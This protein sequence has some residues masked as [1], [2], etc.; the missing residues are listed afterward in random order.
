MRVTQSVGVEQPIALPAVKREPIRLGVA[1]WSWSLYECGRIA[2]LLLISSFVFAP[3]FAT[4]MVGDPVRGQ[5]LIAA[6]TM[7]VGFAYAVV[8][9]IIGATV[10]KSGPRKPGLMLCVACIVPLLCSLWWARPD[11]AG[12]GVVGV[13]VVLGGIAF[14]GGI[15]DLLFNSMMHFS[16]GRRGAGKASGVALAVANVVG[17]TAL[18]AVLWAFELP[19]RMNLP[20]LPQSPL[21]GL[22]ASL[23]E[24]VRI[25]GPIAAFIWALFALPLFLFAT[26]GA[27]SGRSLKAAATEGVRG[28][29]AL[30]RSARG[31]NRNLAVFLLAR[32]ACYDA[33]GAF[34]GFNGVYAAGVMGWRGP[35]MLMFGIGC[36]TACMFGGLLAQAL[37]RTIGP[38][39]ALILEF[40]VMCLCV[41]GEI[42]M[43]KSRV[44][45]LDFDPAAY[46]PRAAHTPDLVF[47][48]LALVA[49]V[50][51]A[52]AAASI[53]TLLVRLAPVGQLG[54]VFGLAAL[55]GSATVWLAPLLIGLFTAHWHSQQIGFVPVL[56][57]MC[58][59][60]GGLLFVRG[61]DRWT[62]GDEDELALPSAV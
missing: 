7:F 41:L 9:P 3:Y 54:T 46:L 11:G 38:R 26:D 13:V 22:R 29:V 8:A 62:A 14:L 39:R 59:G 55:T 28:L 2:Q 44:L 53:R 47:V 34:V 49:S 5:G 19:G 27:P 16:V 37:D 21:F 48:L 6:L 10:D 40:S 33:L 56:A 25:V 17:V 42:G 35:Q 52:A 18:I 61:G 32:V 15:S 1:G 23:F 12:L 45:Y 58:L 30:I 36:A 20:G 60:V 51:L 4:V 50:M 43:S 57:L 24:P 31:I